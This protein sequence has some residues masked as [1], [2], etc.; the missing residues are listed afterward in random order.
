MHIISVM[1]EKTALLLISDDISTNKDLSKEINVKVNFC[2]TPKLI[3]T[4]DIYYKVT[5][6]FIF[7]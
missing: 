6:K 7:L 3:K 2:D 5:A 1:K 4:N